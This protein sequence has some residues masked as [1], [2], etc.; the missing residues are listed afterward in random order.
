MKFGLILAGGLGKRMESS[1]PKVLH[2][3]NN[4]P[5]ICYVIDTAFKVGCES[6]GIIVGKYKPM[7]SET[8]GKFYPNDTR[9]NWID[10]EEPLGTA[11]AVLCGLDWMSAN[12]SPETNILILSGDVPL[13][14]TNTLEKLMEKPNS[15]LT[16]RLDNPQGYGRVCLNLNTVQKIIEEKDCTPEEKKI[17]LVNC[18]IYSMELSFLLEII[19]KITNVNSAQEYY[20]TDMVKLGYEQNYQINWYELPQSQSI[21][22]ANVNTKEELAN[23]KKLLDSKN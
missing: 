20:L 18:G 22:I 5:M 11:H 10:Q 23:I 19:P 9:I 12:L 4:K 14:S 21:E 2:E 16:N 13:I 17:N 3:I 6:V 7:I 1:I 15:I 8:I